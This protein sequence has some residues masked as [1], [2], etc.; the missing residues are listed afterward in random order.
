[1]PP[2][3]KSIVKRLF[4]E[5]IV[6]IDDL[7]QAAALRLLTSDIGSPTI[8]IFACLDE[9]RKYRRFLRPVPLLAQSKPTQENA[10]LTSQILRYLTRK[11]KQ[12]IHRYYW[13]GETLKAIGE[14]YGITEAR[15][16]QI[17]N[18]AITRIKICT[19]P[20]QTRPRRP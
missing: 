15:V 19:S 3:I 1:M 13:A 10:V 20:A 18:D 11:E 12:I 16:C 5:S 4:P 6:P 14:S 17:K 7:E 9:I 2:N 8:V